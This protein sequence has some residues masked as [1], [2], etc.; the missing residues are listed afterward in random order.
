MQS[1]SYEESI[2]VCIFLVVA[3]LALLAVCNWIGLGIMRIRDRET[4]RKRLCVIR[5]AR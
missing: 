1:L 3:A 5:R 2:V 4:N